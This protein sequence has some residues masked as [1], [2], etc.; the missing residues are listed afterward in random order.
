MINFILVMVVGA[1]VIYQHYLIGK[2]E[3][4]IERLEKQTGLASIEDE[5]EP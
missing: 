3:A 1:V 5:Y 2:I 4:R